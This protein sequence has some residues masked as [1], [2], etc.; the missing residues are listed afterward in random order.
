MVSLKLSQ[1]AGTRSLEA[2]SRIAPNNGNGKAAVLPLADH[3]IG[4]VLR[5]RDHLD[6]HQRLDQRAQMDQDVIV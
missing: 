3:Q 2:C 4:L 5:C 1:G 6:L